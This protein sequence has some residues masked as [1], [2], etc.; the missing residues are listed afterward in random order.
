LSVLAIESL[1]HH[2]QTKLKTSKQTRKF[3]KTENKR[4][5]IMHNGLARELVFRHRV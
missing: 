4:H 3:Y 1:C 5:F 2:L